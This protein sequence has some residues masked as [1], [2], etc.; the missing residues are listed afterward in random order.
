LRSN[1][2]EGGGQDARHK[3]PGI[4]FSEEAHPDGWAFLRLCGA[5]TAGCG[6][7]PYP[8]CRGR[9]ERIL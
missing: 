2:P 4:K 9:A 3:L 6:V 5:K 1:G 7:P 8:A